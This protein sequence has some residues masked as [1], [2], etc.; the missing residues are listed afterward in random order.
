MRACLLASWIFPSGAISPLLFLFHTVTFVPQTT[1]IMAYFHYEPLATFTGPQDAILSVSFSASGE[2][3]SAAGEL[4]HCATRYLFLK[5]APSKG[6]SGVYC[7]NIQTKEPV[8]FFKIDEDEEKKVYVASSWV[9]FEKTSQHVLILG[10]VDGQV[11]AWDLEM[12]DADTK[13][14]SRFSL[15]SLH[16]INERLSRYSN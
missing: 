11:T 8:L 7:W 15:R 6:Y 14:V 13:P 12:G 4:F 16:V 10:D 1:I 9:Y 3:I 5:D 2:F